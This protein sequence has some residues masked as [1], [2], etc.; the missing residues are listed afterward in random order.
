MT[1]NDQSKE[2]TIQANQERKFA[3]MLS[4]VVGFLLLI[5]KFYAYHITNSQS[6]FSDALE[7]IVNVVAA[8]IT[9]IVIIVAAKPADDDH[10]YGHGKIESMAS[11]FEGGAILLAGIL[12]VIQAVQVF[13][14]G[15]QLE[16]LDS[17]LIIV[18]AAGIANGLLG[19]FI[20]LRGKK[21]HSE[22]LK[23]SGLH[24]MSDTLTSVGVLVGLFMV[25]FTGLSWIDPVA[26]IVFGCLL[27]YTGGR[28]LY[29]SG[30]ILIDGYDIDTLKIITELFEKHYRP[31]VIQIHF[32]RVIRSG[33]YHHIDC[34]MVL[35]EFWTVL[36]SH[37]FSEKFEQ[38]VILDYPVDGELHI[39]HDPCRRSF[40]ES[41]E[42]LDCPI[43]KD[44][45]KH[46]NKLTFEEVRAPMAAEQI[47]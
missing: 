9:V 18:A 16:Q 20:F 21:H 44:P 7:S 41:C 3:S 6:I 37:V 47:K 5:F 23:S 11:T 8:I 39:H 24:L 1:I 19:W 29:R 4:L 17:G 35:P 10:P 34:H 2:Q 43:R 36:E 26:A 46:R 42:I 13:F 12:I 22:A 31:G 40:C 14:H 25:K 15:S 30:N 28:I 32:T 27:A 38:A 45:F 33:N